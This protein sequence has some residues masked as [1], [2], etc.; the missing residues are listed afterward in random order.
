MYS[1]KDS[2]EVS[3]G[4]YLDVL[5]RRW[6]WIVMALAV[7]AGFTLFTDLR[8]RPVYRASTQLLLQSKISEN[9]LVPSAQAADPARALQNE[10]RII[11]SRQV[12][13]AVAK[14]YGSDVSVTAIAGGEDDVIV[15]SATGFS[16]DEAA[17]KAN[18]YASTYQVSRLDAIIADLSSTTR[19]IEQQVKD[20]QEQI[21]QIDAPLASIDAQL[22]LLDTASPEYERLVNERER[23]KSQS[24]AQR[25]EAQSNLADYTE[26]L[27]VLQLSE[28][29]TT[30][31]G[32]QILNPA[33]SPS[34][35]ISPTVVRNLIQSI[36]IGIFVGVALAFIRDQFDESL[37]TKA[38][39]ERAV[40]DL[41]TIGLVP[42]DPSWRD[43]R[44]PHL[45]TVAAPMSAA[46]ES[47]RGLRTALQY[48]ALDRPI[49]IV[50]ITSASA[51]EGKTTLMSNLALAFAQAGKRVAVVG[52]DLRKPRLHQFMEVDGSVGFTSVVLG[53]LTLQEAMQQSPVHPNI[54]VLA[55]GPRPPNPS[56]LLSLD[57]TASIIRSL[58]Q[59][60]SIVFLDC[61]PVL[62]VT[63]ALV[64]SR[65]VDA[66]IFLATANRTT[67]RSATRSVE[68]LRQVS[69]PL[70]G[71][72]LNGVA[73][74]DTYGSLYEYYGYVR[75]SRLPLVGRFLNRKGPDVPSLDLDQLPADAEPADTEAATTDRS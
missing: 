20:F 61:P 50:Q 3:V 69:S 42:L 41:P 25:A 33:V 34:T 24:D 55:S 56:E 67:R 71:T 36:I 35:P 45:A 1:V 48:A 32:V 51:G 10:L 12:K 54:S 4:E 14:A 18:V 21:N 68:M 62:P 23:V 26:R 72:V 40:K 27:Q 74:E 60:Y 29:L 6:L 30:T 15:L 75:R 66:T 53:D 19:I 2:T 7:I 22:S 38:D 64:L 52:C 65:V 31:G 37:R 9:V 11:N 59:E 73:A 43:A 5:K 28:R 44:A 49:T 13:L 70:L 58:G 16:G 47:Y 46:A 8:Q 57:R 63:D 17:R 39:L